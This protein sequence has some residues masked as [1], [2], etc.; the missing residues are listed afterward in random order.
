MAKITHCGGQRRAR[1]LFL[2][3][4]EEL[5]GQFDFEVLAIAFCPK[6]SKEILETCPFS[7]Q[8]GFL[9]FKRV[10]QK[11]HDGWKLRIKV[12]FRFEIE[13]Q[14]KAPRDSR[15]MIFVSQWTLKAAQAADRGLK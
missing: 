13:A 2:N 10:L 8:K 15:A 4:S 11:H 1:L 3:P 7:N 14:H 5:Q 12:D 6:C 9:P